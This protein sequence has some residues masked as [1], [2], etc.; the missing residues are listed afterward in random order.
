MFRLHALRYRY[1]QAAELRFPD[2]SLQQ[3]EQ[4][5]LRGPSGSGKST[6]L[7]LLAGL[8]QPQQGDIWLAEQSLAALPPAQRDAWRGRHI[9]FTP[10]RAHL[11][12]SLNVLE[13]LQLA[14]YLARLPQDA[15]QCRRVLASLGLGELAGRRPQQ[16]SQGQ[17]Q[18]VAIARALL[19]QPKLL[20]ADEPSASLD[21]A[22]TAAVLDLLQG[23]A[24]QAGATLLVA[25][26]DARVH[27]RFDRQFLLEARV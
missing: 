19:N 12:A 9:G 14:Q 10:Q 8:L 18:R 3:G 5:V 4:A 20:L 22:N 17:A 6:L 16:L 1:G 24:Q 11:L 23:A 7:S 2:W 27:A 21:D 25:S 15:A 26:H 13:N